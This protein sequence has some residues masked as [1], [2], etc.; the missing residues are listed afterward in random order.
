MV[1]RFFALGIA[2]VLHNMF[3]II[4]ELVDWFWSSKN[5]STSSTVVPVLFF[6]FFTL[7]TFEYFFSFHLVFFFLLPLGLLALSNRPLYFLG[8][9]PCIL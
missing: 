3:I 8:Y 9:A 2:R 1:M 7:L 4:V 6:Y 5:R